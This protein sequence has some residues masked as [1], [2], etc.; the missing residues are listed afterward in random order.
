M[1]TP[2][3]MPVPSMTLTNRKNQ[4][5]SSEEEQ[6]GDPNAA[7]TPT[8][9]PTGSIRETI[10]KSVVVEC[11][12]NGITLYPGGEFIKFES[13]TDVTAARVAIY[14]HV[15]E[16][17]VTWGPPSEI[18]RWAPVVE[19]NVRPDGLDRYYDLRLSMTSSGLDVKHR[20]LSWKDDVD[21]SE[22]FG[23]RRPADEARRRSN[24]TMLR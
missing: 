10:H 12:S 6:G 11:R 19:F 23:G 1:T 3:N 13:P 24:E 21:F 4:K 8:L 15:A 7:G 18:H 17:M 9:G 5:Q 16:Q 2:G 14:K 22:V 20:L